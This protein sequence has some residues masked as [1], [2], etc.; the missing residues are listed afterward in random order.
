[1]LPNNLLNTTVDI[2]RRVSTGRD[3]L[4]N[5]V[6]GAPTSGAGWNTVFQAI[7][8]RLAFSSKAVNFAMEGERVQPQGV[9]YY[10]T[11]PTIQ[12]EDRVLTDT[13]IEYTVTSIVPGYVFGN[14]VDHFEALLQLP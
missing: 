4:N 14:V 6:Y 8:V 3:S 9:M 7:P 2:K 1:M 12:V 10:N 13:G 5:P 11:G